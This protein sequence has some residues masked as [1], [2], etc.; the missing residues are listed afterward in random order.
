[1]NSIIFDVNS[2]RSILFLEKEE[3][4]KKNKNWL[5]FCLD[6]S[7]FIT[8]YKSFFHSVISQLHVCVCECECV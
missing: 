8:R 6:K 3:E 7:F 5:S 4:K 1:M 2:I